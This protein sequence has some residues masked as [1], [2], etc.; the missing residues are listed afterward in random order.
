[1]FPDAPQGPPGTGKSRCLSS[2]VKTLCRVFLDTGRDH[3]CDEAQRYGFELR[4]PSSLNNWSAYYVA[5]WLQSLVPTVDS[6][7]RV[8]H[9]QGVTE[10]IKELLVKGLEVRRVYRQGLLL[11]SLTRTHTH[12]HTHTPWLPTRL[13]STCLSAGHHREST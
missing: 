9:A 7:C 2:M 10:D 4:N 5:A 8:G 3:E 6:G 11:H 1:M 13:Q 12:T